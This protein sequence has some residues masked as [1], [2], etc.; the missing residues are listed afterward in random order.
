[1]NRA[2][3]YITIILFMWVMFLVFLLRETEAISF[4]HCNKAFHHTA[5]SYYQSQVSLGS[6]RTAFQFARAQVNLPNPD[7]FFIKE[8]IKYYQEGEV[9][10]KNNARADYLQTMLDQIKGRH[11]E[12]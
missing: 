6:L 5:K 3:L 4:D 7:P 12:R 11:S 2:I 9:T 8:L 1:M 10:K